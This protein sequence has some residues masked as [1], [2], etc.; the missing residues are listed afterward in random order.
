MTSPAQ[1]ARATRSSLACLPCRS[2]HLKCDG[3]RPCC[4]RC[5]EVAQECHYARSRRGGL[6]RAALAERRKRLA[7]SEDSAPV[8]IIDNWSPRGVAE[9]QAELDLA[10]QF[11]E[12]DFANGG[13]LLDGIA[14]GNATSNIDLPEPTASFQLQMNDIEKDPLIDS[15]YKN[16]HRFHPLLLPRRHMVRHYQDPTKQLSLRPV[17]AAMRLIGYIY[18]FHE[19]SSS[20]KDHVETCVA[21][22]VPSDPVIVQ[23]RLLYS[24]ALFWYD[25]KEQAKPEIDHA[26]RLALDLHMHR[27]EFSAKYGADDPVARESW[28]R[29]WWMLYIV[30]AYYAGTLGTMEF[31]VVDVDAT[32]GLPCEEQEYESG[33]CCHTLLLSRIQLHPP[34]GWFE[35]ATGLLL[36]GCQ[37]IPDPKTLQDFDCREFASDDTVFSSFAYLIGAVKCVALAVSIAPKHAVKEDS[38]HVIQAADSALDGWLLLL[39]K[40]RKQVMTKTGEIDELMFQAHLLIHV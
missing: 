10:S 9:A 34:S 17:I 27:E 37:V 16:F 3:K 1:N 12:A 11:M 29:T 40:D 36:T 22:A 33:V 2:R 30:D 4:T 32:V 23:G 28:R 19:W 8:A 21:Q 14:L 26:I 38:M 25:H 7:G 35:Y 20:L 13:G 39:P 5:A 6:D 31:Q 15:Y 24:I 18:N